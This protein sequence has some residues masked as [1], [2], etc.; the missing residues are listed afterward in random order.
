MQYGTDRAVILRTAPAPRA[1]PA[2]R[3]AA[4]A[5]VGLRLFALVV[6]LALLTTA[7]R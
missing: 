7:F 5:L 2:D 1:E 4:T 3:I 6:L